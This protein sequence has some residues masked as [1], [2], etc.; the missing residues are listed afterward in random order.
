MRKIET[1][2]RGQWE[3]LPRQDIEGGSQGAPGVALG[4]LVH[5]LVI[6]CHPCPCPCHPC[7]HLCH[8]FSSLSTSFF[9]L[10][11]I[12]V[13]IHH[14]Y[15]NCHHC[16][17]SPPVDLY[18]L[19]LLVKATIADQLLAWVQ[20]CLHCRPGGGDI[21][22]SLAMASPYEGE[23]RSIVWSGWCLLARLSWV[24]VKCLLARLNW[25]SGQRS[26]KCALY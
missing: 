20:S 21:K 4:I 18:L 9:T 3:E 6:L 26:F 1:W 19:L 17:A 7:L 8:P 25:M 24:S 2:G 16:V 5:V 10:V 15:R 12:L 13:S 11:H 14:H 23:S 22:F